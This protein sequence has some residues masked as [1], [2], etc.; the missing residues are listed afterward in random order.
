MP[1][2]ETLPTTDRR[3][4]LRF[5]LAIEL[6][7]QIN[8]RGGAPKI[9]GTGTV[10]N[11]GSRGLAFRADGSIERGVRLSISMA[12]PAKLDDHCLLR[13]T[14]DGIV[15]RT[16]G[17]LVVVTIEHPEFRTA[18]KGALVAHEELGAVAAS[19]ESLLAPKRGPFGGRATA[20]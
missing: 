17:D 20:Y 3:G 2:A 5:P 9:R 19:I 16:H 12:W 15:L 14:F 18:G 4:R 1:T 7:Y 11:I 10:E 13:L 6:K 8:R